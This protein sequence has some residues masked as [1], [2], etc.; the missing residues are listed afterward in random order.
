ME[1]PSGVVNTSMNRIAPPT[2]AIL[3]DSSRWYSTRPNRLEK[4][5]LAE[6]VDR[7]QPL[8]RQGTRLAASISGR[9]TIPSKSAV[10]GEFGW[11]MVPREKLF[12]FPCLMRLAK[13]KTM[14][15][16]FSSFADTLFPSRG[17]AC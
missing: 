11:I 16:I 17:D 3:N 10:Y 13:E 4:R 15:I 2:D 5:L 7:H 1:I 12:L 14:G 6:S 9:P 8:V